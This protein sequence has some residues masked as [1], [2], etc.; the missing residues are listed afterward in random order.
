MFGS[1]SRS[2]FDSHDPTRFDLDDL[3]LKP[4]RIA[5][6]KV[7]ESNIDERNSSWSIH[8]MGVSDED[9]L[10]AD[11]PVP[12]GPAPGTCQSTRLNGPRESVDIG[13]RDCK[14]RGGGADGQTHLGGA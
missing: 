11:I 8:D 4:D 6:H 12:P 9:A 7:S 1:R 14:A 13:G 10:T 3:D 2:E 5:F